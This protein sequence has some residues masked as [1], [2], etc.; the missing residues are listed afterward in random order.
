MFNM[1][2]NQLG[3][4]LHLYESLTS[5]MCISITLQ[6]CGHIAKDAVLNAFSLVRAR[7]PYFRM[8]LVADPLLPNKL[9]YVE[10]PFQKGRIVVEKG[11]VSESTWQTR[12]ERLSNSHRNPDGSLAE[13]VLVSDPHGDR[14]QIF[15]RINHG[16][17]DGP[18][19]FAAVESFLDYLGQVVAGDDVEPSESLNFIDILGRI[20]DGA[21]EFPAP[22]LPTEYM[23]PLQFATDADPATKATINGTWFDLDEATTAALVSACHGRGCTI[24]GALTFAELVA[25]CIEQAGSYPL[26]QDVVFM[27]PANMRPFVDPPVG[28]ENA[29]CGSA[30][31]LWSQH[32]EPDQQ[33]W[34]TISAMNENL[35]KQLDNRSGLGWWARFEQGQFNPP[36]TFMVS[37]IGVA[38]FHRDYG[39]G[40]Q[41]E[42]A[43][44][45]G[46]AYDQATI[47]RAGIMTHA[48]TV[49]ER[50]QVTFAT[51]RPPITAE[52][53]VQFAGIERLVL[54]GLASEKCDLIAIGEIIE[55]FGLRS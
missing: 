55:K 35:R 12:L 48:Y 27:A 22:D 33:A 18:G 39:P 23:P 46:G 24:Q 30:G 13:I 14:H 9:N 34:D 36:P 10:D 53:A 8:R 28:N 21:A 25:T 49:N 54:E 41:L 1:D 19:V 3:R 47:G 52:W 29:V 31:V 11:P 45:L 38:P 44:V 51:T 17:I 37:S 4:P 7:H 16:G 15:F 32:I 42:A 20:P 50:F 40:L 26:P 5:S 6:V 2:S 43:W